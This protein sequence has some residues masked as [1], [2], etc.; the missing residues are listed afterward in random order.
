VRTSSVWTLVPPS[1][2]SVRPESEA[3]ACGDRHLLGGL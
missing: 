3:H 1:S 2:P